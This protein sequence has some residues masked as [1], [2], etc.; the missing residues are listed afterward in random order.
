[1]ILITFC[2]IK[3]EDLGI[4]SAKFTIKSCVCKKKVVNLQ[5]D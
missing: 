5:P 1:M 3:W 2:R 4:Q